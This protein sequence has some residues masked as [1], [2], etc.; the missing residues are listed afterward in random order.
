MTPR[1]PARHRF[2][3]G[4]APNSLRI[5]GLRGSVSAPAA[6]TAGAK[7][8]A[9]TPHYLGL[10]AL[11]FFAALLVVV[12]HFGFWHWTRGQTLAPQIIGSNPLPHFQPDFGW[13]GVEIFFVV[14]GFVISMSAQGASP[15]QFAFGR[16]L[17]L[18][19][20]AWVCATLT[21]A[22]L[23]ALLDR[24]LASV[25]PDYLGSMVFWPFR[26]IDGVYW[27]L[28]IEVSFYVLVYL[29]MRR[30]ALA[31]LEAIAAVIG[32]GSVAFWICALPMEAALRPMSGLGGELHTLVAKAEGNRLLQLLLVQHGV[33]FAVGVILQNV[34]RGERLIPRAPLLVVLGVG[35][36]LEIIGE[37]TIIERAADMELSPIPALVTFAAAMTALATSIRWNAAISA[38]WRAKNGA[39]ARLGRMTYPLY[40]THNPL[41]FG[42]CALAA[43]FLGGWSELL[44]LVVAIGGAALIEWGPE[45]VVRRRLSAHL[46]RWA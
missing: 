6:E 8:G 28:G 43:P 34:A 12:Y 32:L 38:T 37:N 13:V 35:C 36:A 3:A 5:S 10:D 4:R 15:R 33:F 19:P 22:I 16:I 18:A 46:L 11:R 40:L 29:I 44:G 2:R 20:G 1:E 42:T 45:R 30:G 7:G 21:L 23:L 39:L 14:S 24:S 41:I 17:R 9:P 27:T 25:W 31:Q 26:A